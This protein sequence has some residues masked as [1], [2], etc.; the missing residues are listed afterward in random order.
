[1]F[2]N[3][4]IEELKSKKNIHIVGAAGIE[5]AAI[6]CF[7]AQEGIKNVTLHDFSNKKDFEQSFKNSRDYLKADKADEAYNRLINTGFKIYYKHDYLKGIQK[8]DLIFVSQGWYRYEANKKLFSLKGK[9]PFSSVT[10]LYFQLAPCPIIGITGTVGK[11]TT[12]KLVYEVLKGGGKKVYISGNDRDNPPVLDKLL[13]MEKDSYLVLEI[14]NRQLINLN[15]SPHIAI[16]TNIYPNHPDDHKNFAEYIKVKSNIVIH[17]TKNDFAILN[18]DNKESAEFK[19][20]TPARVYFES[21]EREVKNGVYLKE[22]YIWMGLNGSKGKIMKAEELKLPG[23]HN[24]LNAMPAIIVGQIIG[25][26]KR[27]MV[28]VLSSFKGLKHRL[29]FVVKKGG[30]SF[31]E[32]SQSTSP[33]STTAAIEAFAPIDLQAKK[34]QPKKLILIMGGYRLDAKESDYSETVSKFFMPHVKAVLFIGKVAPIIQNEFFRQR[35]TRVSQAEL[36]KNCKTLPQ[37]MEEAKKIA[38]KGDTILLSPGAESFG[39]FKDYRDRGD[40]FKELVNN[41]K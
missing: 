23:I 39:E 26:N 38:E 12:T 27:K 17:Q 13:T 2:M 28:S 41:W 19:N 6:A 25:L 31:Y 29:E 7:L 30:I 35:R 8:A 4:I 16:V 10:E 34:L 1:M 18:A 24:L 20:L 22:N 3:K 5:G 11:S 37:A 33:Y 14:S 36:I 40:K 9:I 21:V 15:Y 32:D